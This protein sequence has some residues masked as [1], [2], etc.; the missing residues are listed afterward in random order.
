MK[1]VLFALMA[2]IVCQS[3][4]GQI[5]LEHSYAPNISVSVVN[6]E[7]DGYK[8]QAIDPNSKK[9]LLFNTDH[10]L[11]KTITFDT[12]GAS[13][14]SASYISK[15]LFNSDDAL[16]V[17][18]ET[19]YRNG[20][21]VGRIVNETGS[22]LNTFDSAYYSSVYNLSGSWKLNVVKMDRSTRPAKIYSDIYSLPGSMPGTAIPGVNSGGGSSSF[23]NPTNS[24]MTVQY[25][26]NGSSTAMMVI[27]DASG[28]IVKQMMLSSLFSDVLI[29]TGELARGN[30]FY[31]IS[32]EKGLIDSK[33]FI[34]E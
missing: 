21:Y 32:T 20:S 11:W 28:K 26:L 6:I 7:G 30:Y 3:G 31:S 5:T 15:H 4:Y 19:N 8:Y 14:L 12:T 2:F 13:F 22:I 24:A 10:S 29:N 33:Q 1:R 17:Y 34:V 18:L 23:P 27:T 16:E 9:L 25:D